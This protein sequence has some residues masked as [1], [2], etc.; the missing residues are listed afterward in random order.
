MFMELTLQIH[1]LKNFQIVR[2]KSKLYTVER[3]GSLK[4]YVFAKEDIFSHLRQHMLRF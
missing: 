2:Y 3:Q 1:S 4:E